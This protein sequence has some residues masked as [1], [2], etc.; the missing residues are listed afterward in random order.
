MRKFLALSVIGAVLGTMTIAFQN[1]TANEKKSAPSLNDAIGAAL[2][3]AEADS[4]AQQIAL[5]VEPSQVERN[6]LKRNRDPQAIVDKTEMLEEGKTDWVPKET[7]KDTTPE[8]SVA[9]EIQDSD[10]I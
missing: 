1:F 3:S 5:N 4:T 9:D 7:H 8:D 2:K 6:H 10:G